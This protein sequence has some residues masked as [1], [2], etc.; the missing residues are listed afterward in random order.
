VRA[1]VSRVAALEPAP[2]ATAGSYPRPLGPVWVLPVSGLGHLAESVAAATRDLGQPPGQRRYRGHL[3]LAR[4]RHRNL[5]RGLPQT[6]VAAV[7]T[8]TEL[9]LV[10]SHLG[11]KG[12]RYEVVGRW[13]LGEPQP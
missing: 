1:G 9:T 10:R 7:W 6:P 4:A 3:T 13:P 8:V 12:A 11:S 5:L 2:E